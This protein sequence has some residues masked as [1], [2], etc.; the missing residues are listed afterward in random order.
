MAQKIN[1]SL[2]LASDIHS[3][4]H[5]AAW[6]MKMG[7][8][9]ILLGA[10]AFAMFFLS[11]GPEVVT[12]LGV[13]VVLSGILEAASAFFESYAADS[14]IHLVPAI[15]AVPIAMLV[16]VLPKA[17]YPKTSLMMSSLLFA[18]YFTVIGLFRLASVVTVEFRNKHWIVLDGVVTLL[19]GALLWSGS[20]RLGSWLPGF[21]VAVSLLL[22]GWSTIA[23]GRSY[24]TKPINQNPLRAV[25]P[26]R[27]PAE[28]V[29]S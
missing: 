11:Q 22:R 20:E 2:G 28:L 15:A 19:L 8:V 23:S 17:V 9:L 21:A 13:L 1:I 29:E 25:E 16:V 6:V 18:S 4:K 14:L 27:N 3:R 5:Q 12:Q 26:G 7:I 24:P 10:L